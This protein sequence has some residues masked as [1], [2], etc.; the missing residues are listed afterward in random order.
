MS[1]LWDV[2]EAV[3]EADALR[4]NQKSPPRR[5]PNSQRWLLQDSPRP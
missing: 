1:G 2:K 3:A 4:A 5:Y